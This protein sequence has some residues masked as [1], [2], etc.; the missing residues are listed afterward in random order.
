MSLCLTHLPSPVFSVCPDCWWHC[1]LQGGE[2]WTRPAGTRQP[3]GLENVLYPAA[4]QRSRLQRRCVF[5]SEA[6]IVPSLL[7]ESLLELAFSLPGCSLLSSDSVPT[8]HFQVQLPAKCAIS[9]CSPAQ[10]PPQIPAP[11]PVQHQPRKENQGAP[12]LLCLLNQKPAS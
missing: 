6:V 9:L 8:G 12:L 7:N 5:G 11:S 3:R 10:L 2:A 1:W 4:L